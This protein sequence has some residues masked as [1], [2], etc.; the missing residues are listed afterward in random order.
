ML[1]T[2]KF[3]R[4]RSMSGEG[5]YDR[6]IAEELGE[7]RGSI[8][9][10]RGKIGVTKRRGAKKRTQYTLYDRCG[11]YLFEGT[12]DRCASFLEVQEHTVREYL[13]RF[14]AGM[15]TPVE[16]HVVRGERL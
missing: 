1:T 5:Y 16:I 2:G 12:I 15:R 9:Y 4:I 13:S 7:R 14:R 10:Y 6:E 8:S 3:E 11:N